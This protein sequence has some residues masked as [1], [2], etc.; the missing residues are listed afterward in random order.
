MAAA[1]LVLLVP[2]VWAQLLALVL[3]GLVGVSVLTPPELEPLV[4]ERLV[5][6]LRRSV[7]LEIGWVSECITGEDVDF[8]HRVLARYPGPIA[9]RERAVL[10]HRDRATDEGRIAEDE[11]LFAG[12]AHDGSPCHRVGV[13]GA[14]F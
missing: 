2:R 12:G 14:R 9:Y 1:V 3:G 10:M 11:V 8:C 7:A 6:P 13:A 4:V 5:V